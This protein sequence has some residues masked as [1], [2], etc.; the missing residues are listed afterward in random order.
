MPGSGIVAAV[1]A[2]QS[3][4]QGPA[5][6]NR[7][8]HVALAMLLSVVPAA[9]TFAQSDGS[10]KA[11]SSPGV[12]PMKVVWDGGGE[13][14]FQNCSEPVEM[15]DLVA[16]YQNWQKWKDLQ[17]S[18]ESVLESCGVIA[19]NALR[20]AD[21]VPVIAT[22]VYGG[23]AYNLVLRQHEP[24]SEALRGVSRVTA[25][26]LMDSTESP[27]LNSANVTLFS[28]RVTN[29]IS[30]QLPEFVK[31]IVAANTASLQ[32]RSREILGAPRVTGQAL[33]TALISTP[34]EL[35]FERSSVL[36]NG[37]IEIFKSAEAK[38]NNSKNP[39]DIVKV[40]VSTTYSN[41][42][43]TRV[44]L[45]AVAGALIGKVYGAERMKVDDG[46]YA[47]DPLDR[48]LAMAAVAIHP[49]PYDA[50][51][52]EMS[53]RERISF[54]AGG[55]LTPAPGVGVGFS[56]GIIRNLA[57]NVGWALMWVP[58]ARGGASPG[59]L[60]PT[61]GHQLSYKWSSGLFIGGGYVFSK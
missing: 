37:A 51:L 2:N 46:K 7:L 1:C 13:A 30:T 54:L 41:A 4:C 22:L 10:D 15:K 45:T 38:K 24:Y 36:E 16:L 35:P 56:V 3:T 6:V 43:W 12:L 17:S 39:D 42:P 47:S 33:L 18:L 27:L 29:P 8:G 49:L 26:V 23:E 61:D 20:K 14:P 34:V 28:T 11:T 9:T 57:A 31:A 52:S 59:D 60:A 21:E 55:V 50:S 32:V 5:K 44:D 40:A 25:V 58:T 53:R 48:T 19:K